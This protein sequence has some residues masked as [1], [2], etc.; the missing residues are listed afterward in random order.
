MVSILLFSF[1]IITTFL[2]LIVS[3]Q[4]EQNIKY[5]LKMSN[6]TINELLINSNLKSKEIFS[7]NNFT[8]PAIRITYIDKDGNVLEDSQASTDTLDNHNARKEVIEARKKGT[9]ISIR[10]SDSTKKNMMYYA[11]AFKDGNII[12]SSM[13]MEVISGL[14]WNTIRYYIVAIVVVFLLAVFSAFRLANVLVKPIEDLEFIT[15]KVAYGELNRRVKIFSKDEIGKL[16]KTFNNM[17]DRLQNTLEEAMD[18]Q[19]RLEAILK[20]M[21]SGVIAVD[22]KYRVIIFKSMFFTIFDNHWHLLKRTKYNHSRC[23]T[24]F[25]RLFYK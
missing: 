3:Y 13:S 14:E 19:N 25:F 23:F 9:G 18:K 16:A 24:F 2:L 12:R 1:V 5:N 11:T 20:S 21:D 8:D 6:Q 15:S 10:F 17:A 22:K 7:K 4:Y